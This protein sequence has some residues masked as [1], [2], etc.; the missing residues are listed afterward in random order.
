[1]RFTSAFD[2]KIAAIGRHSA[3]GS[4][5]ARRIAAGAFIERQA[6]QLM[7]ELYSLLPTYRALSMSLRLRDNSRFGAIKYDPGLY[8]ASTTCPGRSRQSLSARLGRYNPRPEI[9]G[10]ILAASLPRHGWRQPDIR[11]NSREYRKEDTRRAQPDRIFSTCPPDP[12]GSLL[13]LFPKP[14]LNLGNSRP[15][16][17]KTSG[18]G[19]DNA[20]RGTEGQPEIASPA[21][22]PSGDSQDVF[23]F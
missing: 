1:M 14:G 23:F 11:S 19:R 20:F 12:A 6:F 18:G 13:N 9:E 17:G 21:E 22:A 2:L 10:T 4:S 7:Y 8:K 5:S 15:G 3:Y 16:S